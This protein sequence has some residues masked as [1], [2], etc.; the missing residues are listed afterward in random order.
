MKSDYSRCWAHYRSDCDRG[1]SKE[2]LISKSLFPNKEIYVSGFDWCQG[3]EK[4]VGI[5]ALQRRFLCGKHNNE[6]SPADSAAKDVIKAF[7]NGGSQFDLNG[8]SFERWLVKTAINLSIGSNLHIGHGMSE[9]KPGWPSPYLL[10]V[11]FGSEILCAKMGAYFIFPAGNYSYR[12]G[13]IMI[14]PIHRDGG[15]GG[16]VFGLRGQYVFLN[17]YPGYAP[18][19]VGTLVPGLLPDPIGTAPLYYRPNFFSIENANKIKGEIKFNW[20]N[21]K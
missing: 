2:H 3:Q 5:N 17:I 7:E 14:V 4:C 8:L 16:F 12:P 6:L 19:P 1:L 13:E 15:I 11:A 20:K 18:P 21:E 10:A 9:S